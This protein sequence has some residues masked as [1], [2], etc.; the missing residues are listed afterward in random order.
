VRARERPTVS[1][2]L[3]WD[4]VEAARDPAALRFEMGDVLERVAAHGDL[5]APVLTERQVRRGA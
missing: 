2:P 1:T 4:E 3:R 5:F